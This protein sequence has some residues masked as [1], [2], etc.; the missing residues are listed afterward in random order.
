M[1]ELLKSVK[2]ALTIPRLMNSNS[3]ELLSNDNDELIT[4]VNIVLTILRLLGNT[5]EDDTHNSRKFVSSGILT[6]HANIAGTFG[7]K[8]L[9]L[10]FAKNAV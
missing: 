5:S 6:I 2:A 7:L 1:N 3:Y 10:A 9:R 8:P 4:H